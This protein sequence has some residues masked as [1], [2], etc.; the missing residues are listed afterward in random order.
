MLLRNEFYGDFDTATRTPT[1]D[2]RAR[3]DG[4]DYRTPFQIDRDRI[5]H[6]SAF[7]RL[8]S[9]TQVF[10][11]GEYDFYRTRLTHSIEVAQIG[12]SLSARLR[13]MSPDLGPDCFIDPDLVEAA[14]LSHDIGHPPFGHTGERTLHRLMKPWGGFEGNAQTLRMLTDTIFNDDRGMNPTRALMD[15]VLKYKSLFT[16]LDNPPNHFLY[17]DQAGD[18]AFVI[19]GRAFPAE[20]APG[21]ARDACKSIE[22]QIM[23]WADD[24]AY[25]LNDVADGI[26]AGF[27]TIAKVERWANQRG[28]DGEEAAQVTD[29]LSAIR[30]NRVESRMNRKIGEFIAA[31]SLESAPGHFLGDATRRYQYRLTIDPAIRAECRL[32]KKLSNE[33]VFRSHQLQQLDRKADYIV[34]RLFDVLADLYIAPEKP[35]SGHFRVLPEE[36]EA[37]IFTEG[38]TE[39]KRAR[40]VCDAIARMTDSVAAHMYRRLFDADFGSIVDLV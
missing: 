7:R 15:G 25:S 27:I 12:R 6:T 36:V 32:Y 19:D 2:D 14:C 38:S 16:D 37:R 1:G 31:A 5:I 10:V 17:A 40:Q 33:L 8:Q 20:Y 34:T 4:G 18:L 3:G 22:C 11:S 26:N 21:E 23:D 13:A 29:L 39:A 9:K 35:G 30:R 24:T 28:L